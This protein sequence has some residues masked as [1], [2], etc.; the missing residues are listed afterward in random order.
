MNRLAEI[1]ACLAAPE[2]VRVA[3]EKSVTKDWE[4]EEGSNALG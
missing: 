3:W 1:E 2:R 4:E